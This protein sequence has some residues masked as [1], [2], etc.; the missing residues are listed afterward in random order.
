MAGVAPV[1][2]FDQIFTCPLQGP[3]RPN[4]ERCVKSKRMKVFSFF[5]N[6]F[7][8]VHG[9]IQKSFGGLT[10]QGSCQDQ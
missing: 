9:L 8:K 4:I 7:S 3:L 1:G 5:P 6:I 10:L 2:E